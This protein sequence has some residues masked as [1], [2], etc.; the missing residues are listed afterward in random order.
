M[1]AAAALGAL[2]FNA[3]PSAFTTRREAMTLLG[4]GA[5]FMHPLA[6]RAEYY[7]APPPKARGA[8][9]KEA[10][11]EAKAYKY[12]KRPDADDV[13]EE[14][15][16]AAAK[17]AEADAARAAGKPVVKTDNVSDDLARLGLKPFSG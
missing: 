7:G 5:A 8:E 1:L 16:Q 15:K 10:I 4:A 9:Y 12:A 14:F 2:A 11:E 13:S 6:T 17:R 3:P